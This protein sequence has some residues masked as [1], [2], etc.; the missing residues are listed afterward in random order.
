MRATFLGPPGAGKGT[1]AARLAARLGIPH[2]STGD[3]LRAA[4][5]A[6]TDVGREVERTIGRGEL[7][8]DSLAV[9]LV[10]ERIGRPDARR[11][12]VLD[13]FPR[14]IGQADSFDGMLASEG[15]GLDLAIEIGVDEETLLG[16]ILGRAR[17]ARER[18]QPSRSDDSAEALGVRLAAYRAQTAPL[19]A[20]YGARG[21]L[22]RVDGLASIDEVSERI[23]AEAAA[24]G[25]GRAAA[26]GGP[27]FYR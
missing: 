23:A 3:M 20:Y 5:A 27:I 10:A 24:V 11:G 22:R 7:V 12:F 26:G 17:E 15:L 8:S 21:I 16:R 13:G 1:Q 25:G 6:G 9:S 4:V 14:T 2:L 19:V 18:G